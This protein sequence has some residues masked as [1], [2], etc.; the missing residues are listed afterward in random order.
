M[1]NIEYII[2]KMNNNYLNKKNVENCIDKK[3]RFFENID[4]MFD[5][6][7]FDIHKNNESYFNKLER[8]KE[9]ERDIGCDTQT[10]II[11]NGEISAVN[12]ENENTETKTLNLKQLYSNKNIDQLFWSLY[13][14]YSDTDI[15][16]IQTDFKTETSEKYKVIEQLQKNIKSLNKIKLFNVK[17]TISQLS[18]TENIDINTM[19][20]ICYLYKI[21]IA[22]I[23]KNICFSNIFNDECNDT[24]I[25][26]NNKIVECKETIQN[27]NN[28]YFIFTNYNKPL[29]SE[30][31]YKVNELQD[32]SI[33]LELPILKNEKKMKKKELYNQI[34]EYIHFTL[35]HK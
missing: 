19:L 13:L 14:I 22:L 30:S 2:E 34:R 25:Y 28:N 29:M 18:V 17:Q 16:D 4:K 10:Q 6:N 3:L 7:F 27:I 35:T 31:Q 8:E 26:K 20:T 33:K 11:D 1:N 32:F 21:N 15:N 12:N 9:K 5:N 23:Y 24:Y